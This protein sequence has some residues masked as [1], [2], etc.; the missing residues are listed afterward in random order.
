MSLRI[1][2]RRYVVEQQVFFARIHGRIVGASDDGFDDGC[3]PEWVR[4]HRAPR[5]R[6]AWWSGFMAEAEKYVRRMNP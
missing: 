1:I 6:A 5:V 3:M 4:W 2:I